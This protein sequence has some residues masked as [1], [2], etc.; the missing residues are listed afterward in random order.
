MGGNEEDF[1]SSIFFETQ[2]HYFVFESS[3]SFL[4]GHIRN[5]VLALP[6]VLKIYVENDNVLL[7]LSHVVQFNVETHNVVSTLLNVVNYNVD[8]HNVDSILIRRCATSWCHINLKT[9]LNRSWNVC[10]VITL[11]E[12]FSSSKLNYIVTLSSL[13]SIYWA[14]ILAMAPKSTTERCKKYCQKHKEEYRE[15]DALGKRNYCQKWKV[16]SSMRENTKI[17]IM[18]QTK[19]SYCYCQKS[20]DKTKRGLCFFTRP[21]KIKQHPELRKNTHNTLSEKHC[22]FTLSQRYF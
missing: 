12:I 20:C 13:S 6:N 18:S 21:H 15:K 14:V 5:V 4:N 9:T 11:F 8:L 19:Y 16:T 7:T 17:S 3:L 10:W 2:K 22:F 1:E